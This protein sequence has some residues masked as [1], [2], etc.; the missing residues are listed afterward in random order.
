MKKIIVCILV[1]M[2][3]FS[4]FGCGTQGGEQGDVISV[5]LLTTGWTNTP[6]DENDP[7]R[8]WIGGDKLLQDATQ[9][10]IELGFIK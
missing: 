5:K 6:T 10:F 8:K 2:M 1:A 9:Q 3:L 7:Y 4:L